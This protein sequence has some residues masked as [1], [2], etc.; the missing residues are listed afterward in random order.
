MAT[1]LSQL[2]RVIANQVQTSRQAP[3]DTAEVSS[4][5]CPPVLVVPVNWLT[6][7]V[8]LLARWPRSTFE[9]TYV[10]E[11][12]RSIAVLM[13]RGSCISRPDPQE[14]ILEPRTR[15]ASVNAD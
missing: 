13:T 7:A 8:C 6:A 11:L 10:D 1:P 15:R 5:A 12:A 2:R 9:I 14:Q 3:P 4:S